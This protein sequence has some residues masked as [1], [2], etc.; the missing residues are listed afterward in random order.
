MHTSAITYR[1]KFL[2]SLNVK[3]ESENEEIGITVFLNEQDKKMG[4]TPDKV[5]DKMKTWVYSKADRV[6]Q[7]T[8]LEMT[9]EEVEE[10]D[11]FSDKGEI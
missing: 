1:K 10:K 8:I 5:F 7:E 6:T 11:H 4:I 3:L 9:K 2:T